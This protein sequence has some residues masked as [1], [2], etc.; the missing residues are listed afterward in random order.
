MTRD[1]AQHFAANL[2]S[3]VDASAGDLERR[4]IEIVAD[5]EAAWPELDLP[6]DE[7]VAYLAA[8]L[9]A[10]EEASAQLATVRAA[11]LYLACGCARS[12]ARALQGFDRQYRRDTMRLAAQSVLPA[13]TAEDAV[14][15]IWQKLFVGSGSR[16]PRIA[17]YGGRGS[18]KSWVHATVT[19]ALIDMSREGKK[20][21]QGVCFEDDAL[22]GLQATGG[23]PEVGYLKET[24]VGEFTAAFRLAIAALTPRQRN[25]LRQHLVHSLS[26]DQLGTLYHI[27]RSTAARQLVG[28][29]EALLRETKGN[30]RRK[31]D[32][33]RDEV[34]SIMRLIESR[35]DISLR[36]LF[37]SAATPLPGKPE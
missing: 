22:W 10:G 6:P 34:D 16:G 11:D 30:L 3:D 1:L 12:D 27:H 37:G 7:F 14:Q 21:K 5:A 23:D 9:R 33:G 17:S 8:R 4:L 24:Y 28:A 25:L 26:I 19:R 31:L 18:L 13:L 35:L 15:R 36:N 2:A 29:R 32:I 20:V